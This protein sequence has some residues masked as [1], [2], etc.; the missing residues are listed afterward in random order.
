M[1]LVT[2]ALSGFIFGLGLLVSGMADPNKVLGFLDLAGDWDPSLALVMLG[3]IAVAA[4]AYAWVRRHQRTLTGATL[5]LPK[6]RDI[7]RR[8]VWGSAAFGLGWG[9]AG[10]CPGPALINAFALHGPALVFVAAMLAG[11]G[12]YGWLTRPGQ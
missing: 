8:L 6:R 5:A 4:P 12:L 2:A 7:D 10:L 11:M 9:L 3:A 1:P